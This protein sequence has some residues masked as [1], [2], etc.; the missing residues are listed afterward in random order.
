MVEP[1][2]D[3]ALR[4][5]V[6][7][8]MQRALWEQVTPELRGVAVGWS[9]ELDGGARTIARFLYEGDLS[10]LHRECVSLVEAYFAADFLADM[11]TEFVPVAHCRS[12]DLLGEEEWVYLRWE[13]TQAV[14]DRG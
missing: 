11:A 14:V 5:A 2:A 8:S 3:P 7:L 4:T 1:V 10:D 13:P 6:L 12:L 9:G